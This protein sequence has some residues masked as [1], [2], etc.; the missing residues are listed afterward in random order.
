MVAVNITYLIPLG[1]HA[2]TVSA[3]SADG[4][5]SC[6]AV[7]NWMDGQWQGKHMMPPVGS[8]VVCGVPEPLSVLNKLDQPEPA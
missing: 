3:L 2:S 6:N 8:S 5:C 1:R 7:F 4:M